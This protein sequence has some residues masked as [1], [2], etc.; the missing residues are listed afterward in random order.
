MITTELEFASAKSKQLI[1]LE[2]QQCKQHFQK[3]K[4]AI[5]RALAGDKHT[6]CLYC[7]QNCQN[8]S[9]YIR[10]TIPC[11]ECSMEVIRRPHKI[12]SSGNVFCNHSCAG[13]YNNRNKSTGYR[14]SKMEI[15]FESQIKENYPD[16]IFIS[17]DRGLIGLE[18]DFL[19]PELKF[20]LELNGIFHYKSIYKNFEITQANDQRKLSLCQS[21]GFELYVLDISRGKHF[22]IKQ[23][24][25]FWTIF[26][27]AL[28]EKLG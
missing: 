16:L 26:N 5:K 19:F 25:M 13:K 18:L 22:L 14:R 7:S 24:E 23:G 28:K 3:P 20:A 10:L 21:K 9:M 15:F 11:A 1:L 27:Q 6:K 2:C 8:K 4:S 12:S 17:N